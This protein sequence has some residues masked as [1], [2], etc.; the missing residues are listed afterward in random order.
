MRKIVSIVLYTALLIVL[1]VSVLWTTI[2]LAQAPEVRITSPQMN[3][4]VRGKVLINGRT[5]LPEF[6]YYKVEFGIGPQ[7]ADWAIVGEIHKTPVTDG[8]LE[9]WDTTAL[10]DGM[11]SLRLRVVKPDGNYEEHFVPQIKI[12][13]SVPTETPTATISP[14]LPPTI[15]IAETYIPY[16]P[17]VSRPT[18]ALAQPTPTPTLARPTRTTASPLGDIKEFGNAILLGAGA[19]GVIFVLVGL[20]LA[21]RRV[22]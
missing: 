16:T 12:V 1:G 15:A 7:P 6:D 3:A 17:A 20:I 9:T 14:T 21:I 5:A 13:N 10:P 18:A 11:Y 4:E 2:S 19:M 22:L 8:L